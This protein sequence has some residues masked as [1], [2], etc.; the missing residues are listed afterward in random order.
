MKGYSVQVQK[1]TTMVV[2]G[3]ATE[4][5]RALDGS[6]AYPAAAV[7]SNPS[8]GQTVYLGGSDVNATSLGWPLA[9][10]S[11]IEVDLVGDILYG[12]TSTTSQTVYI[13]RRGE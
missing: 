4:P 3:R 5:G 7:I 9:A 11:S 10:G 13:L 12:V 2:G 8:G 1:T 6:V